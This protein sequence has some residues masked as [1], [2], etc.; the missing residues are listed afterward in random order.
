MTTPTRTCHTEGCTVDVPWRL[1]KE[2]LC[3]NHY[4]EEAFQKLAAEKGALHR[5]EGVNHNTLD[6]LLVQMD[7][8]VESLVQEDT[9][10]DS[11]QRSRLLELLLG[12]ANLNEYVRHTSVP[13]R[14]SP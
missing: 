12:V 9:N 5:G 1:E 13:A 6:W 8:A 7:F 11:E 3:L 4:L 2:G 10:W 14:H